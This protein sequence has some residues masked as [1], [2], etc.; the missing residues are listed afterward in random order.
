MSKQLEVANNSAITNADIAHKFESKLKVKAE[1]GRR[2]SRPDGINEA[3]EI[4]TIA[5]INFNSMKENE[6][7]VPGWNRPINDCVMHDWFKPLLLPNSVRKHVGNMQ[8]I[9]M[10]QRPEFIG[11]EY[12]KVKDGK[13]EIIVIDHNRVVT[14]IANLNRTQKQDS[15]AHQVDVSTLRR[16]VSIDDIIDIAAFD[17]SVK[18]NGNPFIPVILDQG[19]KMMYY[20]NY[21]NASVDE[22]LEDY[23]I[24]MEL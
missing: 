9:D 22:V 8:C 1:S 3:V 24:T 2:I 11:W 7:I 6:V 15:T 13:E 23:F 5:C 18:Y 14:E 19:L 21:F 12:K 17:G 20:D 10:L 16:D 4:L